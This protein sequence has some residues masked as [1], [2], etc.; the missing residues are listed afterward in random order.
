MLTEFRRLLARVIESTPIKRTLHEG[1]TSGRRWPERSPVMNPSTLHASRFLLTQRARRFVTEDPV[2]ARILE[3]NK[4]DLVGDGIR[5]RS[6]HPS[7]AV[8][9]TLQRDFSN[10]GETADAAGLCDFAGLQAAVA[11]DLVVSGEAL[12]AFSAAPDGGPTLRRLDPDQL[13]ADITRPTEAGGHVIQGVEFD[14]DGRIVAY[15][16][17][18]TAQGDPFRATSLEAV[19]MPASEI[20]HVFRPLL[21]GQ[22]RGISW[23][24]PVLLSAADLNKLNDALIQRTLVSALHT[25]FITTDNSTL[26][27][28]GDHKASGEMEVSMEPGAAVVLEPGQG[29][30]FGNVPNAD[31]ATQLMTDT[32]RHIASGAGVTYESASGDYSS[33][34]FSSAR[35]AKLEH[36]RFISA[37]QRHSLIFQFCRP[38]IRRFVRWQVLRGRVSARA[39]VTDPR[40]FEASRWLPPAWSAIDPAKE[41]KA[42]EIEL[43]NNLRSRSEIIAERG[44]DIE[45]VDAEIAADAARLAHLGIPE[46]ESPQ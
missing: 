5:Y 7:D 25:A 35:M 33:V 43:K 39:F 44:L 38:V 19:R 28:D 23:F 18:R 4:A 31:G 1:A 42:A 22:V 46:T 15:H 37:V 3:A 30:E 6:A 11:G 34:N 13:A 16:V 36:R 32:L 8:R 20:I 27:Y 24:A 26:P 45:E 21:P 29:V 40:A 14:R 41:A 9:E 10:W 12:L 2:G 17:R